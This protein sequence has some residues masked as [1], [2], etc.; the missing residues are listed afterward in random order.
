MSKIMRQCLFSFFEK[1][2]KSAVDE[3]IGC[4]KNHIKYDV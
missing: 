1:N 4:T 2:S 3:T